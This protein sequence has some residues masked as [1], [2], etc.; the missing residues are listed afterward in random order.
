M[1]G[2][3]YIQPTAAL[4]TA[5]PDFSSRLTLKAYPMGGWATRQQRFEVGVFLFLVG[6]PSKVHDFQLPGFGIRG[7]L[8]LWYIS[9]SRADKLHQ[10]KF[11]VRVFGSPIMVRWS[12]A[13]YSL[14]L[15]YNLPGGRLPYPPPRECISMPCTYPQKLQ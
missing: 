3:C 5:T 6:L 13:C 15:T 12:M 10:P 9:P 4:G 8:L 7:F 11:E 14:F 1:P 2:C